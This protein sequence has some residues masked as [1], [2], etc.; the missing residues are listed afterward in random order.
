MDVAIRAANCALTH[1]LCTATGHKFS[2]EFD[3]IFSASLRDHGRYIVQFME[4][5]PNWRANHYLANICGLIFI[6][7]VLS[8]DQETDSWLAFA[9]QELTIETQ[10]QIQKDGSVFEASTG[11]HKLSVEMVVYATAVVLGLIRQEGCSRFER[12]ESSTTKFPKPLK[13]APLPLY[14][15]PGSP[16]VK[17][18][19]PEEY[20]RRLQHAATF[21]RAITKSNGCVALIGDNDS[22]RFFR[23]DPTFEFLS[24]KDA[25]NNYEN[26]VALSRTNFADSYPIENQLDFQHLINAISGII[27]DK[28]LID[29][30]SSQ[31]MD[32]QLVQ[33]LTGGLNARISP[34]KKS[35]IKGTPILEE[36]PDSAKVLRIPIKD[37]NVLKGLCFEAFSDFGLYI[38]RSQRFF[39]A[40]RCGAIGQGGYGG[41]AHNDQL[42]IELNIDGKDLIKDPGT[43][44]YT[45][46]SEERR[47]YR[48]IKAHFTPRS[49]ELEPGNLDLGDEAQAKVDFGGE[50]CFKGSHVGF[51]K[52]IHRQVI[53]KDDHILIAD[54]G[55]DG[56]EVD[57]PALLFKKL[58]KEGCLQ[59]F[60]PGYGV[61]HL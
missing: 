25:V 19:F 13:S 36:P 57:D 12:Y 60:C 6:A 56:L 53:I 42:G 29:S 51:G 27:N 58:N 17:T 52:R 15:L 21:T 48:S 14:P 47:S 37:K 49:G 5:D 40:I 22:G 46:S 26:L 7:A 59:P 45:V 9:V 34:Q 43:Y 20:F 31:T 50:H 55:D 8:R 10:R 38:F 24:W 33:A 1:S 32:F 44:R 23:L 11:Y 18:P 16:E 4:W 35:K 3:K 39:L 30:Q 54:W 2:P 61:R 28:P 41:H